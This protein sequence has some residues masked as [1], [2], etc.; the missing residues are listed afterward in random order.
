MW[1]VSRLAVVRRSGSVYPAR[2][3]RLHDLRDRHDVIFLALDMDCEEAFRGRRGRDGK[4]PRRYLTSHH[5]HEENSG[6]DESVNVEALVVPRVG[7]IGEVDVI[8]RCGR[9]PDMEQRLIG[10]SGFAEQVWAD[11]LLIRPK[12][13]LVL[14]AELPPMVDG[15]TPKYAHCKIDKLFGSRY[16][17]TSIDL[18]IRIR[19]E[20]R[21]GTQ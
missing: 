19:G 5:E 13:D 6:N 18:N 7:G 21:Y 14:L 15:S 2:L 3:R 4:V 8:V 11:W 10:E 17:G 20:R 1:I 9:N 16:V 12:I